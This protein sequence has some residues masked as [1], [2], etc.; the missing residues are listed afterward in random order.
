MTGIVQ[1]ETLRDSVAAQPTIAVVRM[2][3]PT[4]VADWIDEVDG[5]FVDLGVGHEVM[6]EVIREGTPTEATVPFE[7]PHS[8]DAVRSQRPDVPADSDAPTF[9]VG[10]DYRS[11]P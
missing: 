8:M 1:F 5:L 9:P 10:T 4:I 6:E 2:T 3:R 7:L 11:R